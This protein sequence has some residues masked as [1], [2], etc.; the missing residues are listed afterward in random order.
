MNCTSS[1]T[2]GKSST[3]RLTMEVRIDGSGAR[4]NAKIDIREDGEDVD[5][6]SW[7]M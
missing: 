3:Q 1:S 4:G 2:M 5:E 6:S 7:Q